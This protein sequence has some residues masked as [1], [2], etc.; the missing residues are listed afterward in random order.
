MMNEIKPD[1]TSVNKWYVVLHNPN[2]EYRDVKVIYGG[3]VEIVE[4]KIKRQLK[5]WVG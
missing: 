1:K 3:S 2:V 5:K 4:R